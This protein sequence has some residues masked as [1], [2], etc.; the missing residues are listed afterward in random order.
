MSQ[1]DRSGQP[2]TG[3]G[4]KPVAPA[5]PVKAPDPKATTDKKVGNGSVKKEGNKR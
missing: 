5:S 3:F 1:N 4:K 2:A